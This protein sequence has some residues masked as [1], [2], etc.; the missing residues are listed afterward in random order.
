M[1][2]FS[3]EALTLSPEALTGAPPLSLLPTG[4]SRSRLH[5][6]GRKQMA[7]DHFLSYYIFSKPKIQCFMESLAV[8]SQDAEI[9]S[10]KQKN[11]AN[12]VMST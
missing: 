4:G 7:L 2:L 5:N 10:I 12:I 11:L 6:R 9:Y 1:N 3:Q 8:V